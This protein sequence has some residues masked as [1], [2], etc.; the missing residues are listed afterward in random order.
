[1]SKILAIITARA[2]SKGVPRK[3]INPLNGVPL[4]FYT[5]D[6]ARVVLNDE[7]ICVSTNDLELIDLIKNERKLGIPFVRPEFLATDEASTYD[8]L[9]HAID[10]YEKKGKQYDAILLLQPTSPLRT[11]LHIKEAIELYN[12]KN[13]DM[14]VSVKEAKSNPYFTLFEENQN[15]FL[16]LSKPSSYTRRQ[17]CPKVY[18]YNGAIYVINVQSLK[19]SIMAEFA[20]IQKY[21]MSDEV[22]IDIDTPLDWKIAEMIL[23]NS[24]K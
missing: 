12:S 19:K 5:I 20:K 8:V 16:Q 6:A 22:S 13:V 4:V 14:V 21:R 7:D 9:L 10:F 17:D 24:K 3:N 11:A 23:L 1:M 15:G 18:E 2:G